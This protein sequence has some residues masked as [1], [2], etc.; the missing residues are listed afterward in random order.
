MRIHFLTQ[1]IWLDICDKL[2][3]EL[4]KI[5]SASSQTTWTY[6]YQKNLY[7]NLWKHL[8]IMM[9]IYLLII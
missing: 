1:N 7:T 5:I 6:Q 4:F 8:I 2:V 9:L 3:E